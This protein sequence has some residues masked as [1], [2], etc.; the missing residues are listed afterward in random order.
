MPRNHTPSDGAF[1]VGERL[2]MW[3]EPEILPAT[4]KIV[5]ESHENAGH[6]DASF[7]RI[8]GQESKGIDVDR[9]SMCRQPILP[10]TNSLVPEAG[11]P[12][13]VTSL[14]IRAKQREKLK[15]LPGRLPLGRVDLHMPR[16]HEVP[17]N[18]RH[19][20]RSFCCGS[21]GHWHDRTRE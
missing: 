1:V 19:H 15:R 4:L 14:L 6:A 8:G 17:V 13:V 20:L 9:L 10:R 7:P 21:G 11:L 3:G 12:T 16:P 2:D 5:T 18:L